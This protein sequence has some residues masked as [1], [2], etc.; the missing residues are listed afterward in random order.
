[1]G[2]LGR[3]LPVDICVVHR[4]DEINAEERSL[5]L[6][7]VTVIGGTRLWVSLP[8]VRGW[9]ADGFNIPRGSFMVQSFQL[10]G[11]LIKFSYYD[12]MLRILHDPPPVAPF[13][14]VLKCWRHQLRAN[15]D[16][17]CF[18]AQLISR[19]IPA[20]TWNLSTVR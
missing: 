9:V 7:L 20:H 3:R 2:A 17:L 6:A 1:L 12:D 13:S 18:K 11:F 10:E 5:E 19:G 16:D 15:V 8:K 4:S 14:L